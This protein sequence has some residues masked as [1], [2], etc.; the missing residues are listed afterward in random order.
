MY[1]TGGYYEYEVAVDSSSLQ[2]ALM[3]VKSDVSE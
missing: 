1:K 2:S 3:K